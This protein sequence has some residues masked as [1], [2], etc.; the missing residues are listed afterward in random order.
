MHLVY[1]APHPLSRQPKKMLNRIVSKFSQVLQSSQE[2]S[3]AMV[4]PN[5]GGKQGELLSMWKLWM[6]FFFVFTLRE[7]RNKNGRY[8]TKEEA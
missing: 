6:Q 1:P 2:K 8:E 7:N 4:T 5:F 3:K